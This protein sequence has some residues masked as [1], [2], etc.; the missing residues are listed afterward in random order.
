MKRGWIILPG[1]KAEPVP[2]FMLDH[3]TTFWPPTLREKNPGE[4]PG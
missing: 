3:E 2:E 4:P 1:G